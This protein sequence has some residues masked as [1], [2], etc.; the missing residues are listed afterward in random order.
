MLYRH[1]TIK[2]HG[3]RED[4][5]VKAFA[6]LVRSQLDDT[7][8]MEWPPKAKNFIECLE[9]SKPLACIYNAIIWSTNPRK[10]KNKNGYADGN[11]HEQAEEIAAIIQSR[12]SL[13]SKKRSPTATALSLR[14]HRIIGSK[15]A[16]TLLHKCGMGISYTDV[17][18]LTN[19]W[20][21]D[22]SMNYN[23]I[24]KT[25]FSG[26]KSIHVTFENS[27]G[28]QQTLTGYH[29]THHTTGTVFQTNQPFDNDVTNHTSLDIQTE[30]MGNRVQNYGNYKIQKK[31]NNSIFSRFW[32]QIC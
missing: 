14:L 24:L 19:T 10:N 4:D 26:E 2:G 23:K 8:Q 1:A 22:I 30:P 29:T 15:E 12:E 25:E 27:D 18:F 9:N 7:N 3:L 21:K 11:N 6:N 20:A 32:W 13:I 28:K 5:I 17:R 31:R 16:R